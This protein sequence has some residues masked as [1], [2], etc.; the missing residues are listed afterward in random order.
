MV[1]APAFSVEKI[2]YAGTYRRRRKRNEK[3][4]HKTYR[5]NFNGHCDLRTDAGNCEWDT[6]LYKR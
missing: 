4:T 6:H 5:R 1:S 3:Y 2:M